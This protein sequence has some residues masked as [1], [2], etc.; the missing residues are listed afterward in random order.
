M[1][2]VVGDQVVVVQDENDF[3]FLCRELVEQDR[4]HDLDEPCSR[5]AVRRQRPC[6][7]LGLDA[8]ERRDG[9]QEE[10][11]RVVVILIERQPRHPIRL[12]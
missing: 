12:S 1:D 4:K 8:A 10:A 9:I 11:G 7:E 3:H 2:L 5:G 6:A